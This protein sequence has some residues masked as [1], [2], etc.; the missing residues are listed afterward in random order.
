MDERLFSTHKIETV[1]EVYVSKFKSNLCQSMIS[2]MDEKSLAKDKNLVSPGVSLVLR[3]NAACVVFDD[4]DLDVAVK[5]NGIAIKQRGTTLDRTW[6]F[7]S[8]LGI[9]VHVNRHHAAKLIGYGIEGGMYIVLQFP[10]GNLVSLLQG[11]KDKLERH[12]NARMTR[13]GHLVKALVLAAEKVLCMYGS[14]SGLSSKAD[15]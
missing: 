7:L 9:V 4:V 8:E 10:H 1:L 5:G 3:D 13:P 15:C 11:W 6:E 14:V 12:R 2:G